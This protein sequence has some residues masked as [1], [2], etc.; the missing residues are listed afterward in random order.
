MTY[1]Q[2]KKRIAELKP[3]AGR[4]HLTKDL[5]GVQLGECQVTKPSPVQD[6]P[7][8]VVWNCVCACGAEFRKTAKNLLKPYYKCGTVHCSH[9]CPAIP[10]YNRTHGMTKHPAYWVWRSM[11]DR[12]RNPNHQAYRNYGGRGIKVCRA[13]DESFDAFWRD[14]GTT[15]AAGL[16]LERKNNNQGYNPR[17]CVWASSAQQNRNRRD[18]RLIHTPW[19]VVTVAE[20][21]Q[22]SGIRYTTLLYRLDNNWPMDDWFHPT[23][24]K[25]H[26]CTT[27]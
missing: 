24:S 5:T 12:C 4:R 3:L 9:K 1:E 17:N 25:R 16:T 15:Y 8:Q 23:G 7:S 14:L 2:R 26:L 10:R 18:C 20:A 22:R 21:A 6:T 13:W 11:K 19:G 27:S